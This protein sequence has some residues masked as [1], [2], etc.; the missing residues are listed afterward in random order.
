[1]NYTL[2]HDEGVG[3]PCNI[4]SNSAAACGSSGVGNLF[5]NRNA[6]ITYTT[7]K[8]ADIDVSVGLFDPIKL[9]VASTKV[10]AV[11]AMP[12]A[13]PPTLAIPEREI[14]SPANYDRTPMP[15]IEVEANFEKQLNEKTKLVLFLNG[16]GQSLAQSSSDKT[17]MPLGIGGGG[18]IHLGA[19]GV[20]AVF[21]AGSGIGTATSFGPE[22]VDASGELRSV[23]GVQVAGNYRLLDTELALS[24]G[25][26]G[27]TESDF[28]KSS[29]AVSL[30]ESNSSV[31]LKVAQHVGPFVFSGDYM[32]VMTKWHKGEEQN[33]NLI[34]IGTKYGW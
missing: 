3:H 30:V 17:A 24:F 26:V 20:G 31:A 19:L 33:G 5:G 12:L 15:R 9:A 29:D 34:H 25:T 1:M 18:R 16:M 8:F 6:Q 14:H 23:L 27:A 22:S 7:P 32:R 11:A 4:D 28:D 2:V 10:P 21:H 13:M